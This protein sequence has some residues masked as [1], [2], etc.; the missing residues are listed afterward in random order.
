MGFD[1]QIYIHVR[2]DSKTGLP[3]VGWVNPVP[4]NPQDY[5]VPEYYREFLTM[6]NGFLRSYTK[7]AEQDMNTTQLPVNELV[8]YFPEWSKVEEEWGD[9]LELNDWTEEI[10]NLFKEALEWMASKEC[11]MAYWS[12]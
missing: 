3:V 1:W 4:Y 5:I 6:R 2:T 9:D 10:H 11:F 7:E 8:G 12:Y